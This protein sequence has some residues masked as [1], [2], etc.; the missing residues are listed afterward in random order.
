[1]WNSGNGH[2]IGPAGSSWPRDAVRRKLA[3]CESTTPLGR[4]VLP[5]VKKMTCGS[6]STSAGSSTGV[7]SSASAASASGTTAVTVALDRR[8]DDREAYHRIPA[9]RQT[10]AP[11]ATPCGI[12]R[13]QRRPC[14]RDHVERFVG[15]QDAA[16]GGVD[17][18]EL[19]QRDEAG[20][21]IQ[22][23]RAPHHDAVTVPDPHAPERARRLVGPAVERP[24]GERGAVERGGEPTGHG[25]GG[26]VE[27]VAD[28]E[29]T[30]HDRSTVFH[31]S[32]SAVFA[33]PPSA[34]RGGPMAAARRTT[35][36]PGSPL[37]ER[38]ITRG[39][40][41]RYAAAEED[42]ARI[43][44]ATYR[45]IERTGTV[46]PRVRDILDEAG[47][48]S[49]TFYRHFASKDELLLVILDDGR[50]RLADYLEHRMAKATTGRVRAW[51]E[52][53]AAQAVDRAAASR[54]RP[55]LANTARIAEQF[56]TEQESSQELLLALLTDA[57]R[58]AHRAGEPPSTCPTRARC[59]I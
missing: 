34:T 54:T 6:V 36:P 47:F 38:A 1:M 20:H 55:F 59:S 15:A 33:R 52:G 5:L 57:V 28:E 42:V 48:S 53:V 43:I 21:G 39:L 32:D 30:G 45:V 3:R 10:T 11:S 40:S 58:A 56:P 29:V 19:C 31:N 17:C 23:G 44:E 18:A 50:R 37:V 7:S 51:I 22:A 49:P 12:D 26:V 2:T 16:D 8:P 9:R 35:V 46:D 14:G 13:E 41:D 25:A 24:E 27:D 4:P